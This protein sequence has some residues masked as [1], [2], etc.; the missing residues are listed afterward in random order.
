MAAPA[1]PVPA[2]AAGSTP[3]EQMAALPAGQTDSFL[4]DF[5]RGKIQTAADAE[6]APAATPEAPTQ[7]A[8]AK[9][10]EKSPAITKESV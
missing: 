6:P 2:V 4:E 5:E 3:P 8:S 10:D 7:T 1:E 9:Q